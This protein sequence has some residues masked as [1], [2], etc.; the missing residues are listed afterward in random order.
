MVDSFESILT[1]IALGHLVDA[2]L[3]RALISTHARTAGRELESRPNLDILVRLG[4]VLQNE[5]QGRL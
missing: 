2:Q 3:R 1:A 4:Q 5:S